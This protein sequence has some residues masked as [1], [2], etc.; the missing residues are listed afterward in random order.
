MLY[1]FAKPEYFIFQR[2]SVHLA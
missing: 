1:V 2:Y